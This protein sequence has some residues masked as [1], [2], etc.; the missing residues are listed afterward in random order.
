[1]PYEGPMHVRI[2]GSAR[3]VDRLKEK[4]Q[5][6]PVARGEGIDIEVIL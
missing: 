5:Q 3:E 1:M 6:Q 2:Q 4:P